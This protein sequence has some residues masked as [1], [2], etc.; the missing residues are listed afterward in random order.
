MCKIVRIDEL[1]AETVLQYRHEIAQFYFDNM[2]TCSCLEH[3][4][5]DQAYEKIGDLIAHL[6]TNTC[7]AYGAFEENEIVGYIWAYPH[8]FREEE[9]MYIS[10]ISIREEYRG[11]G[12]G[13]ELIFLIEKRAKELGF[14]ALYLHAE[15]ESLDALRFYESNGYRKERIQFR[16]VIG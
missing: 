9:R 14:H 6:N 10:E 13:R 1:N 12:I 7:V 15:A 4:T 3:Y 5:Y 16:K 8:Q 2:M 11:R